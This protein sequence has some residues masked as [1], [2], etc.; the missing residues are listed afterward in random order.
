MTETDG[1]G[2]EETKDL[3]ERTPGRSYV[4][5]CLKWCVLTVSSIAGRGRMPAKLAMARRNP[6][7]RNGAA[8]PRIRLNEGRR[9]LLTLGSARRAAPPGR[10]DHQDLDVGIDNA[11]DG[12]ALCEHRHT[13]EPG[14][15]AAL[16]RTHWYSGKT[17]SLTRSTTGGPLPTNEAQGVSARDTQCTPY[18]A[19]S[20]RRPLALGI[21]VDAEALHPV[22]EATAPPCCSSSG[23]HSSRPAFTCRGSSYSPQWT[24]RGGGAVSISEDSSTVVIDTTN[25]GA[26]GGDRGSRIDTT[27]SRHDR[28]QPHTGRHDS[29]PHRVHASSCCIHFPSF[30]P[31][32]ALSDATAKFDFFEGGAEGWDPRGP[33]RARHGGLSRPRPLWRSSRMGRGP[34][35]TTWSRIPGPLPTPETATA[36]KLRL[37]VR[38]SGPG[39]AAS[40][41]TSREPASP[42]EAS[43]EEMLGAVRGGEGELGEAENIHLLRGSVSVARYIWYILY[44]SFMYL[45]KDHLIL[46]RLQ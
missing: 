42:S 2:T 13:D 10:H 34:D 28:Q 17:S 5:G 3:A 25:S 18:A 29:H 26:S 6:T 30:T 32:T 44:F 43:A 19:G 36:N 14:M 40:E 20:T 23:A 45:R 16:R 21:E 39:P 41:S 31:P 38:L 12:A 11:H 33:D 1:L 8:R 27:N 37:G 24:L 7:A 4:D 46:M 35:K 15:Q 9:R 22:P